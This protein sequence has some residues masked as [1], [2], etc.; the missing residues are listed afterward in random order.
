M[1]SAL[2]KLLC[3]AETKFQ[4]YIN[5]I[6][7]VVC[8]VHVQ[9]MHAQ[10]T[11][12]AL[13]SNFFTTSHLSVV[14]IIPLVCSMSTIPLCL[15]LRTIHRSSPDTYMYMCVSLWCVYIKRNVYIVPTCMTLIFSSS[16][17]CFYYYNVH[18]HSMHVVTDKRREHMYAKSY[19]D[20]I[21]YLLVFYS[22]GYTKI[23]AE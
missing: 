21:V 22:S 12:L 4:G 13:S 2:I 17:L 7:D 8:G 6:R 18:C 15:S 23:F 11:S 10:L 20:S 14:C 5:N 3:N 16:L 1:T 19:S 9:D